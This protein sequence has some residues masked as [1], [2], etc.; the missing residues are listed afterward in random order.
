MIPIIFDFFLGGGWGG[1]F[2]IQGKYP[3]CDDC[4]L[5]TLA[6]ALACAWVSINGMLLNIVCIDHMDC[7]VSTRLCS[8]V[9]V[10]FAN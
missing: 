8:P 2:L 10:C 3:H 7:M 9:L 6:F 1:K 4:S 5:Q